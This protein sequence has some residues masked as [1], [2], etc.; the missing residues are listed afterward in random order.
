MSISSVA[1]VAPTNL[2]QQFIQ[3]VASKSKEMASQTKDVIQNQVNS[4]RNDLSNKI[5]QV[6]PKASSDAKGIDVFA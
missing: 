2:G 3:S 6:A 1:S 5:K 4:Y